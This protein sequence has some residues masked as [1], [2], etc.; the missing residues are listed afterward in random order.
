MRGSG[1]P[2]ALTVL[3][4]PQEASLLTLKQN[5]QWICLETLASDTRYELQV[6][7]KPQKGAHTAWSPWSQPLAFRTRAE[8]KT[9]LDRERWL[10]AAL[11]AAGP[12][13][14]AEASELVCHH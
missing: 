12:E 10:G 5:Q 3:S 13:A 14:W 6:R 7:V 2:F 9:E 8:G 1:G 4:L 11:G